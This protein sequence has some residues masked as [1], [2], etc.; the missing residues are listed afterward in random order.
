MSNRRIYDFDAFGCV[1]KNVIFYLR[2]SGLIWISQANN[3]ILPSLSKNRTFSLNMGKWGNWVQGE[4]A[5]GKIA[6]HQN[7]ELMIPQTSF[8]W[9]CPSLPSIAVFLPVPV[10]CTTVGQFHLVSMLLITSQTAGYFPT[11][12]ICSC[13]P[14]SWKHVH[15]TLFSIWKKMA[16]SESHVNRSPLCNPSPVSLGWWPLDAFYR[17]W[18]LTSASNLLPLIG[19]HDVCCEGYCASVS[20]VLD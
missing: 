13:C 2:A 9:S 4:K 8:V 5:M 7:W 16:R 15:P 14:L 6:E 12:R 19:A 11:L 10:T 3:C 1:L 17:V 20:S 18:A